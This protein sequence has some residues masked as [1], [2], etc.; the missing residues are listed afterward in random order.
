[1]EWDAGSGSCLAVPAA[2]L[3]TIASW[4]A[5]QHA[6]ARAAPPPGAVLPPATFDVTVPPGESL[7]AAVSRCPAG[8]SILLLPG[9]HAGPL[10]IAKELHVFG[11]GAAVLIAEGDDVISSSAPK[12][13]VDGL[14]IRKDAHRYGEGNFGIQVH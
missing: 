9:R 3:A 13:T 5:K 8:G 14:V 10:V 11:R 12:A 6:A 1:M 7:Q 4:W 2:E